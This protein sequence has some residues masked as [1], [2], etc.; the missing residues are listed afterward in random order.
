M[1]STLNYRVTCTLSQIRRQLKHF[2][3]D[4]MIVVFD[5]GI[6]ATSPGNLHIQDQFLPG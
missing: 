2:Q 4:E 3:F 1:G 5:C 6:A